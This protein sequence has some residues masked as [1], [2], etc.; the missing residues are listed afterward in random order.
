MFNCADVNGNIDRIMKGIQSATAI[1]GE[2]IISSLKSFF[3]KG[4]IYSTG[5]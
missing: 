3:L 2:N 5:F 1:A 4:C